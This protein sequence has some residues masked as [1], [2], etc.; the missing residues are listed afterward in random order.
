M[1]DDSALPDMI[2]HFALLSILAVGGM[3]TVLP[4][5]HHF[6]VELH[7]WLTDQEFADLFAIAQAAPGPNMLIFALIGWH[8]AGLAGALGAT[9]AICGP[10]SLLA[11]SLDGLWRRFRDASWRR[12]VQYGIAPITVGLVFSTG[13]ILSVA[14]DTGWGLYAVTAGTATL[15]LTTRINPLW[16]FL[17]AGLL[18]LMGVI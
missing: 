7:R 17:G 11:F 6:T 15:T 12:A 18:G 2:G 9:V 8:V 16:F 1:R 4:D 14:A 5:A 13:Y 3:N 10:S